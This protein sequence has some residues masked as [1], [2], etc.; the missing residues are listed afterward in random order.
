MS[1]FGGG[2]RIR[3][4]RDFDEASLRTA[5]VDGI[6]AFDAIRTVKKDEKE[7]WQ[8]GRRRQVSFKLVHDNRIAEL[9]ARQRRHFN[10][11]LDDILEEYFGR[12]AE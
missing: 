9:A 10:R 8:R 1:G 12:N 3:R 4:E 5:S 11:T 2:K 6:A 7:T